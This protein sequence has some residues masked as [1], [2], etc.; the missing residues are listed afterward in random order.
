MSLI[1]T[2]DFEAMSGPLN[3]RN[4]QAV[5]ALFDAINNNGINVQNYKTGGDGTQSNPWTGWDTVITWLPNTPYQFGAGW[6]QC[7]AAPVGWSQAGICLSGAGTG[8]ILKFT[9]SGFAMDGGSVDGSTINGFNFQDFVIDGSGT[10]TTGMY[11]RGVSRG[12]I[13]NV[14]IRNV[15][16]VGFD[17]RFG[18]LCAIR[19][20]RVSDSA[21]IVPTTCILVRARNDVTTSNIS[22]ANTFFNPI[23]EGSFLSTGLSFQQSTQHTQVYGGTA[24]GLKNGIVIGTDGTQ[25]K[26]NAFHCMDIEVNRTDVDVSNSFSTQFLD[27][28]SYSNTVDVTTGAV[29]GTFA[30]LETITWSGGATGLLR[31]NNAGV[32]E[33]AP[34]T[35]TWTDG[36]TTGTLTGGTSGATAGVSS[37]AL[38]TQVY[39]RS[40]AASTQFIGGNISSKISELGN[41]T[42][43]DVVAMRDSYFT[44]N[45]INTIQINCRD[46]NT[47]AVITRID[48][49][50]RYTPNSASTLTLPVGNKIVQLLSNAL[51]SLTIVFPP[52]PYNDQELTIC[53]RNAITTLTLS[54]GAGT[55]I[56]PLTSMAAGTGA[57]WIWDSTDSLWLRLY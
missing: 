5:A 14:R 39:V 7:D 23:C 22:S 49:T 35:G 37:I 20:L 56:N 32:L 42:K 17:L 44:S 34:V 48:R 31:A 54:T 25:C 38:L 13:A 8:T 51:A 50:D 4:W 29:T 21:Y 27:L 12:V 33:I 52:N 16:T 2:R 53:T 1:N 47:N 45:S 43:F 26:D 36:A 10:C 41:A 30:L 40:G 19:N 24:E 55:I 46:F 57:K 18:V 3:Y 9:T 28:G 6:F 11:L 15:T